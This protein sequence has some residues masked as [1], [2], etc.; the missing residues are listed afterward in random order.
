MLQGV[1][2]KSGSDT[3]IRFDLFP[4]VVFIEP[5]C[6]VY[7]VVMHKHGEVAFI[8]DEEFINRHQKV[9]QF[10]L[11]VA[12]GCKKRHLIIACRSHDQIVIGEKTP[13]EKSGVVNMQMIAKRNV[14]LV[15]AAESY[16]ISLKN[17]AGR[18]D[19]LVVIIYR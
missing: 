11:A 7:K 1:C 12:D 3:P 19:D 16:V 18:A 4:G 5:E 10:P 17:L 6:Q 2:L 9:D 15:T 8:F 14:E 13:E